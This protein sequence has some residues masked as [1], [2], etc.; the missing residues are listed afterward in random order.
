M[1]KILELRQERLKLVKECEGIRKKA[2]EEKRY[3]NE[4][5]Q[6]AFD[7]KMAD[8]RANRA[9]EGRVVALMESEQE[10]Q[11][12][13]P[14]KPSP[15]VRAKSIGQA[16]VESRQYRDMIKSGRYESDAFETREVLSEQ[17]AS[18]GDL[19]VPQR[20]PGIITDPEQPLRFRDL[21]AQGVTNSNAVEY[22]EETLFTNAA[23]EAA[24]S[25]QSNLT[26]KAE[27][28]LRF[29][30]KSA[31][32]AT[33]AHWI[34]ASRQVI[35]DASQLQSYINSRLTYGLKLVE[36]QALA[37][38]IVAAADA[39][40][41]TLET[42]LGVEATSRIDHI[43]MA[44][45]Q[46]RQ[47]FYPVTGIVLNPVDWA[48]MELLKDTQERYIWVNVGNGADARLWR[49][50]VVESDAITAGYFLV[51]AFKMGA[52]IWDR[53]GV[54]VRVSE[55]HASYFIQNLVAILAEERFA[56]TIYRPSA[57]VY[58]EFTTGS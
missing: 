41:T 44:I 33:Y 11:G 29:D 34:P 22:V 53:E 49:V 36:D 32:V 4:D 14:I 46:A 52:Q 27:S 7:A 51:G 3:L 20:L 38:A 37:D 26:S 18:A 19:I 58:G 1:E 25:Y 17:A 57:F 15:L 54:S 48:A 13:S 2:E 45:L 9:E 10:L 21:L 24:E 42:T 35:A 43:R 55:H 12:N 31:S 23:A 30:A 5:E 56:L 40:D 16:F 8:I 47:S 6:K 28:A 39:Y 50:P